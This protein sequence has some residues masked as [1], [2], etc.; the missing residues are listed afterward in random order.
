MAR[1]FNVGCG[2]AGCLSLLI[3]RIPTIDVSSYKQSLRNRVGSLTMSPSRPA[4]VWKCFSHRYASQADPVQI[5][6]VLRPIHDQDDAVDQTIPAMCRPSTFRNYR[7][8]VDKRKFDKRSQMVATKS[9]CCVHCH[10]VGDCFAFEF[11]PVKSECNFYVSAEK[12]ED[13]TES[14]ACPAGKGQGYL[15]LPNY[16][17]WPNHYGHESGPCL[18]DVQTQH[19]TAHGIDIVGHRD[20]PDQAILDAQREAFSLEREEDDLDDYEL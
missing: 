17:L 20:S 9:D 1:T 3:E 8:F 6:A 11:D 10:T 12:L 18:N 4:I 14:A 7:N 15:E 19:K 13:G 16:P 5:A 2:E